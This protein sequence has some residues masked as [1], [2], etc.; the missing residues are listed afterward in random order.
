RLGPR[1][2]GAGR[3]ARQL[4]RRLRPRGGPRPRRPA[5]KSSLNQHASPSAHGES[6]TPPCRTGTKGRLSF[7]VFEKPPN[8][9]VPGLEPRLTEPESAGLP[10]TPYPNGNARRKLPYRADVVYRIPDPRAH[11]N[12]GGRDGRG[13]G[14][15]FGV[16]HQV[17]GFEL[18]EGWRFQRRRY[19]GLPA[20]DGPGA[21]EDGTQ[22]TLY[23]LLRV[24]QVVEH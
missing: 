11:A 13:S 19:L 9:G 2:G 15:S 22:V 20:G 21:A 5:V 7:T 12:L 8:A 24:G 14:C 16:R 17:V 1:G 18:A 10:I 23:D 3:L 6:K 4:G